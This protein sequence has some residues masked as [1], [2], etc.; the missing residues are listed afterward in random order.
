MK[1]EYISDQHA[2]D[3]FCAVPLAA[4]EAVAWDTEFMRVGK[5]YYPELCLIQIYASNGAAA[6][7]DIS[8]NNL[9]P[10]PF[11]RILENPNIVKVA[12]ALRQDVESF[13]KYF[14][15]VTPQNMWDTQIGELLCGSPDYV[16]YA[17]LVEKICDVTL[18]KGMQFSNWKK[19]PLSPKQAQYAMNDVK[20]LLDIYR[21]QRDCL[22]DSGRT[23]WMQDEMTQAM[24]DLE[25]QFSGETSFKKLPITRQ[26]AQDS[27][28]MAK[29]SH[30][31]RWREETARIYDVGR[32]AVASDA[33]LMAL[34]NAEGEISVDVLLDT[35]EEIGESLIELDAARD[36][37]LFAA[38]DPQ[39]SFSPSSKQTRIRPNSDAMTLLDMLLR[40]VAEKENIS[41][42]FIAKKADLIELLT[43]PDKENSIDIGWR[44]HVFGDK[45]RRLCSGELALSVTNGTVFDRV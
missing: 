42:A 31:C 9:S 12:H 43:A 40:K 2:F 36:K 25:K 23:S 19:R 34:G 33:L 29:L 24:L 13:F 27:C 5:T 14:D 18:S 22:D 7:V 15:S 1:Y 20:Y 44:R 37:A 10:E 30:L 35:E 8:D 21:A 39:R 16:G 6:L 11:L 4:A 32:T 41:P 38:I 45:A 3:A 17:S 28:M 26:A